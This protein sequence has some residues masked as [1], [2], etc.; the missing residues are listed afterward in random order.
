MTY[1]GA[2]I[3]AGGGGAPPLAL[4]FV[5]VVVVAVDDFSVVLFPADG[6]AFPPYDIARSLSLFF[7]R[8]ALPL[9][10]FFVER[11]KPSLFPFS[12]FLSLSLSL[13]RE[14]E[15]NNATPTT[16][17]FLY[18][19]S[20]SFRDDSKRASNS[21]ELHET[22]ALSSLSSSSRNKT[23]LAYTRALHTKHQHHRKQKKCR[24]R[25]RRLRRAAIT[26][27]EQ[28]FYTKAL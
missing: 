8:R 15:T 20:F 6:V 10:S 21:I 27:W 26:L 11:R 16:N 18:I 13:S 17:A 3:R 14:R 19:R 5:V 12:F 28:H 25:R 4:A 22:N 7:T 2:G 24:R 9:V 23:A 1:F